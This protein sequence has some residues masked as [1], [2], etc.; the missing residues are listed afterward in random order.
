MKKSQSRVVDTQTPNQW[1]QHFHCARPTGSS[2]GTKP[3]RGA[4]KGSHP[5]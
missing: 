3:Q 1:G 2:A 5:P 4:I